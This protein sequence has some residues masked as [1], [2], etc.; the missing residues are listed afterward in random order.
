MII[1]RRWPRSVPVL[2][3]DLLVRGGYSH[4]QYTSKWKD[5]ECPRCVTEWADWLFNKKNP[6]GTHA[7]QEFYEQL[8]QEIKKRDESITDYMR[9]Y[10][11]SGES[12][13]DR[14]LTVIQEWFDEHESDTVHIAALAFNA[15]CRHF[16]YTE[17]V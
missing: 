7:P 9:D 8:Y 17:I 10:L 16:G 4:E 13:F 1:N 12:E 6:Y 3:D 15:T 14:L 5:P 2:T 11:Y